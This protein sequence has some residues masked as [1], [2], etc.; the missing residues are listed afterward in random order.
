M[1]AQRLKAGDALFAPA[2]LDVE[3]V[4]ALRGLA[5]GNLTAKRQATDRLPDST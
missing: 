1:V 4:S 2:H 5:R 3:I